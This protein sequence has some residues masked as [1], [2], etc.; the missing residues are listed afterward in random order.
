MKSPKKK[1]KWKKT[2]PTPVINYTNKEEVTV[3]PVME[4][5]EP[6]V[7]NIEEIKPVVAEETVEEVIEQPKTT[8]IYGG[9]EPTKKFNFSFNSEKGTYEEKKPVENIAE[10]V[11]VKPVEVVQESVIEQP[12]EEL[13]TI[14]EEK[15]IEVKQVVV[16]DEEDIEVL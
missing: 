6:V 3:V 10:K 8:L 16:E 4:R 1:K 14:K 7:E 15:P 5:I 13:Q 11:E 2:E 9:V 12:T